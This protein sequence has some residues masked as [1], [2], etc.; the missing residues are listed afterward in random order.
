MLGAGP[1]PEA[2]MVTPATSLNAGCGN[3]TRVGPA[4]LLV[5]VTT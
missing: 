4:V 2:T 1:V 5:R 3:A